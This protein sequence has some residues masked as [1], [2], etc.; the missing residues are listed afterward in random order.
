MC[1]AD[2]AERLSVLDRLAALADDSL[3]VVDLSATAT[4]ARFRML[5]PVREYAREK[6]LAIDGYDA[7]DRRHLGY[8]EQLTRAAAP[9]LRSSE[10]QLWL[11]R[12][13][14]EAGNL[15]VAALRIQGWGEGN[16]LVDIA[17]QTWIWIWLN[18]HIAEARHWLE[19]LQA[20]RDT[21]EPLQRARLDWVLGALF[22]E[23]GHFDRAAPLLH[24]ALAEFTELGDEEGRALSLMMTGSVLPY[25]GDD[26]LST[27]HSAEAAELLK[28]QGDLFLWVAGAG[29]LGDA[30]RPRR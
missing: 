8:Y 18:D 19:P 26:D 24:Q 10:Q 3:V 1:A 17:W 29:L 20:H 25:E 30:F 22:F 13:E 28:A 6:L 14:Q 11:D 15:G 7:V 2:D 16:R 4:N 23:H 9:E 12:L 21:L 5:E 27:A